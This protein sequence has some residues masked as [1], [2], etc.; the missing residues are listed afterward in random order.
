MSVVT[1]WRGRLDETIDWAVIIISAILICE[2]STE[3]NHVILLA[4]MVVISMFLG[5]E[6]RRYQAYDVYRARARLL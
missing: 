1:T 6:A 5:I 3:G 2:F 4:R